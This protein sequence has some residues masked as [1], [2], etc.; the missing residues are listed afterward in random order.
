[1][2]VTN[3]ND[4]SALT[5]SAINVVENANKVAKHLSVRKNL[6][7]ININQPESAKSHHALKP[8]YL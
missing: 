6:F 7:N 3:V 4:E 2:A 1:M 5:V 8:L